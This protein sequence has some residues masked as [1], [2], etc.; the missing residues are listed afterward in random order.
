MPKSKL[1]T[2][3]DSA[4]QTGKNAVTALKTSID[5]NA[6][7]WFITPVKHMMLDDRT[8]PFL[9]GMGIEA[10]GIAIQSAIGFA[11]YP[12]IDVLTVGVVIL[13]L[14]WYQRK[15]RVRQT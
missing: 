12:I 4:M 11:A 1:D 3:L 5:D 10:A 7:L 9:F 8:I 15:H 13:V 14:A 2:E 6:P